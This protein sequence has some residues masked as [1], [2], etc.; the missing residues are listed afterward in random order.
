MC[1]HILAL[2]SYCYDI[3]NPQNIFSVLHEFALSRRCVRFLCTASNTEHVWCCV[4]R[5]VEQTREVGICKMENDEE[6]SNGG[7]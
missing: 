2:V 5:N 7:P 3:L 4:R 6:K 1:K